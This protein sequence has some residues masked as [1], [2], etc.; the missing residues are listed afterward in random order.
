MN[1]FRFLLIILVV[2]LW[3]CEKPQESSPTTTSP[4]PEKTAEPTAPKKVDNSKLFKMSVAAD[5]V[6]VGEDS[7][8]KVTIKPGS[9]FKINK[10]YPW[11]VEL[12]GAENITLTSKELKK[13][14]F[15]LSDDEATF[16]LDCKADAAGDH[17]LVGAANFSVCN[18]DVCKTFSDE[19]IEIAFQAIP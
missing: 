17:K 2:A 5:D 13:D 18:D 11:K 10:D 3:G 12:Q 1:V 15:A 6:R 4:Q 14:Q 7:K 8:V 16:T 19:P 9:G